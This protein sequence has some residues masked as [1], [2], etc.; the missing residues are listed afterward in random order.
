MTN[1][2][3]YAQALHG[4]VAVETLLKLVNKRGH[5]RLLPRILLELKKLEQFTLGHASAKVVVA[6]GTDLK[7]LKIEIANAM[8]K[9]GISEESVLT[10]VDESIVGG[11]VVKGKDALVDLSYKS[12]L[13]GLY[14]NIVN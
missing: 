5:E 13:V 1:A 12:M 4:G 14:K 2:K 10:E 6:S 3:E 8:N 11:F 7:K 9:L